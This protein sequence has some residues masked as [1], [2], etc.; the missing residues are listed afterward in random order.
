VNKRIAD[1]I[2]VGAGYI[3]SPLSWWNDLLVNVPLAYIFS[4]PFS[5]ISE[6]LFL[7]T[8]IIGYWITN[9]VGI[10]LLHWGGSELIYRDRKTIGIKQSILISIIY[11]IVIVIFVLFGW[12]EAPD[13]YL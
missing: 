8:F 5:L 3:L 12:L 1:I 6:Q 13:K 2:M 10:L 4:Y 9:L 7:P 11:T